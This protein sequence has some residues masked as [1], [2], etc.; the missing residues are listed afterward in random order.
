MAKKRGPRETGAV[1]AAKPAGDGSDRAS[2]G[3]D[4]LDDILGGGFARGR[5][6]LVQGAPGAGKTTLALQFLLA[7]AAYGESGL[8]ISLSE[9]EDE[10]RTNASSHGWSLESI[11]IHDVSALEQLTS[12]DFQQSVFQPAEV[13]LTETTRKLLAVVEE[14]KP[15]RVV[16]DPITELRLLAGDPMRYRRQIFAL[17]QAFTSYGSA[18]LLIE[19]RVDPERSAAS[20]VHSII[21]LEQG[22]LGFGPDR[23][24][25]RVQKVRGHPFREGFHDLSI[26]TGGL[27]VYPAL[28]A[29]EH[30]HSFIAQQISSGLPALDSLLGGGLDEGTSTLLMGPSG[31]GKSSIAMQYASAAAHRG[32]LVTFLMFD[33]RPETLCARASGLGIEF[34]DQVDAGRIELR[35]V[36]ATELS[37]G[38]F[39]A[40]IRTAVEHRNARLVVIDSLSGYLA[41]MPGEAFLMLQLHELLGY[42]GQ[43]A[44]TTL[45]VYGQK[46]LFTIAPTVSD[47]DVSYFTDNVLLFRYYEHDGEVRQ[48]ISVFKRRAGPHERTIRDLHLASTGIEIGPQLREFRGVLTGQPVYTG[49]EA[50]LGQA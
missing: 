48:A 41:A 1:T 10:L 49:T 15:A 42:L 18:V 46:G 14:I 9:T 47:L 35:Q 40:R 25:L 20:L 21:E 37:L 5:L 32:D 39:V 6:H 34:K 26:D 44:V 7:G 22:A 16:F 50:R 23:R 28:L 2:T 17:K 45:L 11:H 3:I 43:K 38:Q 31:I 13:E 30:R 33:E 19:D 4:G 12:L 24:R 27:Q 36:A 8:L 29:A